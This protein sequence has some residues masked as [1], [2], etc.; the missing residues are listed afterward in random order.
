MTVKLTGDIKLRKV[1]RAYVPLASHEFHNYADAIVEAIVN[2]WWLF[3]LKPTVTP[4]QPNGYELSLAQ[5]DKSTDIYDV[6]FFTDSQAKDTLY[7]G[8]LQAAM[9]TLGE[10]VV[11]YADKEP[12]WLRDIPRTVPL[13]G[14][15]WAESSCMHRP[16]ASKA[17][18]S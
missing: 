5:M 3:T 8:N 11:W 12:A 9:S 7:F 10:N 2:G 18:K 1:W 4:N 14:A 6:G 16:L 13:P 15:A 17:S